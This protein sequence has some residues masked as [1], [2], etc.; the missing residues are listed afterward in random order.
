MN[1]R[2]R[3][4]RLERYLPQFQPPPTSLQ[5]IEAL[6]L[7]KVSDEDLKLMILMG[8]D[9]EAGIDRPVS[10]RELA[11]LTAHNA[12]RETEALKMGFRSF[13]DAAAEGNTMKF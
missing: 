4:R 12:R 3:V 9:A 7:E 8:T 1:M 10:E 5:R 2:Q 6:A 13:A 11:V